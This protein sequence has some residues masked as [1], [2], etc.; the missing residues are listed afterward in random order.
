ML[1]DVRGV[2]AAIKDGSP[3]H[4]QNSRFA[5]YIEA[6]IRKRIAADLA[7]LK[8]ADDYAEYSY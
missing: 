4:E 2:L 6:E 1:R 5:A 3:A 7:A 8:V